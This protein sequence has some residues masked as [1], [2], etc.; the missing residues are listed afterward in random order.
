MTLGGLLMNKGLGIDA[1]VFDTNLINDCD[2]W[3][4]IKGGETPPLVS[5][6]SFF[7]IGMTT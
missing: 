4:V 2:I 7:Q 3:I 6:V 5:V 1:R